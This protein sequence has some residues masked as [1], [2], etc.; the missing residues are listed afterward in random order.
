MFFNLGQSWENFSYQILLFLKKKCC[1]LIFLVQ[2]FS[3]TGS[4]NIEEQG[5]VTGPGR[6]TLPYNE[7]DLI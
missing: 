2:N 3:D 5:K 7:R 6:C 4:D 1:E